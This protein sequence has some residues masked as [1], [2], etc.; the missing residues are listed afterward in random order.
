[1]QSKRAIRSLHAGPRRG[2]LE[3]QLSEEC[4]LEEALLSAQPSSTLA[5]DGGFASS[6][7]A[8]VAEVDA[9][10]GEAS[11]QQRAATEGDEAAA[12]AGEEGGP[13]DSR[14]LWRIARTRLGAPAQTY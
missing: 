8:A 6:A 12:A 2:S 1:M 5:S 11:R 13:R 9:E 4:S 10:R 14:K 3:G 7:A